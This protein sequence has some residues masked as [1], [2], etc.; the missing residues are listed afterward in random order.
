MD[1]QFVFFLVLLLLV[2]HQVVYR[3][4]LFIHLNILALFHNQSA[5]LVLILFRTIYLDGLLLIF[6][7]LGDFLERMIFVVVVWVFGAI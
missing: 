6:L 3:V 1:Y 2:D 7:F 4:V 5:G